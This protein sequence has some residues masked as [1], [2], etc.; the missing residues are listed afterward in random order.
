MVSESVAVSAD[1][2]L[3]PLMF[4]PALRHWKLIVE[5]PLAAAVKVVVV[6]VAAL[7]EVGWVVKTSVATPVALKLCARKLERKPLP[8]A[9]VAFSL[10]MPGAV[11]VTVK[12]TPIGPVIEAAPVE[13]GSTVSVMAKPE[14]ADGETGKLPVAMARSA[15]AAKLTD[16]APAASAPVAK[17][18]V[19]PHAGVLPVASGA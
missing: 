8:P 4:T 13:L 15:M 11:G 5:V 10:M 12:T 6:L 2:L 19:L 9:W 1:A 14:L 3:A 7:C 17:N 18:C 16:C